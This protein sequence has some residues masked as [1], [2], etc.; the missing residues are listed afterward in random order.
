MQ[1]ND[2]RNFKFLLQA[3]VLAVGST[4]PSNLKTE[5]YDDETGAWTTLADY[6]YSDKVSYSET[7]FNT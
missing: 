2:G 3:Q 7:D 1:I 4:A 5:L 6:P